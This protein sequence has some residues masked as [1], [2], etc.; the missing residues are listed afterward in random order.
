[1]WYPLLC[2]SFIIPG[3]V[4]NLL[5]SILQPFALV[6]VKPRSGGTLRSG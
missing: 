4:L 1:M 2:C 3:E 6:E 5:M